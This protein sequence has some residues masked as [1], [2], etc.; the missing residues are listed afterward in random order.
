[1]QTYNDISSAVFD[2]LMAPFG[3]GFAVF[4]LIL[5]PVI[6]GVVAL[7]VYKLVSNQAGIARVKSQ[8]S[9]HLLEIRLFSHDIL[10]VLKSTGAILV[11]NSIYIGHNLLPMLVMLAPM[12]ALMVQ[13]VAHYAYAPSPVG[14]VELLRV[15][16]D[17]A[18]GIPTS[19]VA[20]E[21]PEG[22]SLDAPV[23]RT[24]DARVFWRL[25]AERPGDH[26]L[27]V[28][29]GDEVFT[30]TWAVGGGPR[31]VPVKR[32][33]TWEALLYPGEQALDAAAPV[34]S[35][36]LDVHTRPLAWF[37]EGEFGILMWSLVLSLVAGFALKGFFGVTL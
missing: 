27:A 14:S 15:Q 16:L 31:K 35:L 6:M 23:V 29:V 20:L 17:P 37:P 21:L 30:K 10:Q 7:Q 9:M 25:R 26:V 24:A 32:L 1:M 19:K 34:V 22:V 11:K 13:L 5:W 3:H 4:D 18:A 12:V 33:R 2:F 8:I 28:K 36:E